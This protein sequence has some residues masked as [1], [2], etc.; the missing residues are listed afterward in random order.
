MKK[1]IAVLILLGLFST[2]FF[3]S[4]V[5]ADGNETNGGNGTVIAECIDVY[6]PVCGSDGKTYSNGCVAKRA[7][8]SY[9]EGKCGVECPVYT[10]QP[11]LCKNG[12]TVVWGGYD[13][14]GCSLPSKC[15]PNTGNIKIAVISKNIVCIPEIKA[16]CGGI[17]NAKVSVYDSYGNL[18]DSQDTSSGAAVFYNLK[19]GKYTASASA[20]GYNPAKEDFKIIGGDSDYLTIYLELGTGTTPI[21][22]TT[23]ETPTTFYYRNA[24]WQCYDGYEEKSGGETS[25]KPVEVWKNYAQE[26]CEKRCNIIPACNSS[27]TTCPMLASKCGVNSFSVYNECPSNVIETPVCGNGVCES[28]EGEICVVSLPSCKEN[29]CIATEKNCKVVCPQDC[30][31]VPGIYANLDE[32][33]KLEV[34]QEVK[35]SNYNENKDTLKIKF[36]DLFVPKCGPQVTPASAIGVPLSTTTETKSAVIEKYNSLTGKVISENTPTTIGSPSTSKC[37]GAV[38]YAVLQVKIYDVNNKEKTE[39]IK[40]QYGEKKQ[41]FDVVISFVDYD[42]G[43]NTGVFVVSLDNGVFTCPENCICDL[44]GNTM[45]CPVIIAT[46]SETQTLCPDGVCREK[47]EITNITTDCK[48]GCFYS[49]KCL[50]YGL[51]MSNLY[52]SIDNNMKSQLQGDEKCDN[53]FECDSN[54]CIDGTC[55]SKGFFKKFIEWFSSIFGGK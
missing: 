33:F 17:Y 46:C 36:N 18:V 55:V 40:L 15:V 32:K 1:L 53:S 9:K 23:N 30:N 39:V 48:F 27:N 11:P 7:G 54:L 29:V 50:P 12:E 24:Y 13:K 38:P 42:V 37:V 22:P 20:Q 31:N 16:L 41:V 14:D 51:R 10:A 35:I 49:N 52:C 43:S 47:C 45:E 44:S 5:Y 8:V 3:V 21:E 2:L 25:C 6:N 34:N 4:L 19:E 26:S 28:G